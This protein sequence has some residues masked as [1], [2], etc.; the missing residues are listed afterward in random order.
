MDPS[1]FWGSRVFI[2]GVNF[3]SQDFDKS[4]TDKN[5]LHI[6]TRLND[7]YGFLQKYKVWLKT[8]KNAIKKYINII[9]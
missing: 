8:K 2:F 3:L 1:T 5:K 9:Y 7:F 6:E 4:T